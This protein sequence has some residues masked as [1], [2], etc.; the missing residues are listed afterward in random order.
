LAREKAER[1]AADR[2]A[3]DPQVEQ[4][5]GALNPRI[6]RNPSAIQVAAELRNRFVADL[7]AEVRP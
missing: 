5:G 7:N 3:R 1:A 6:T 4:L 2:S